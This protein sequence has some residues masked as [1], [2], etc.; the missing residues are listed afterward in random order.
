MK[1]RFFR[2]ASLC[3]VEIDN[4]NDG[5]YMLGGKFTG[6]T[7]V[8]NDRAESWGISSDNIDVA[9][10]VSSSKINFDYQGD[11]DLFSISHF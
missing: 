1:L 3:Q 2:F 8:S 5:T 9:W 11:E 10:L 7:I 4:Q 6:L